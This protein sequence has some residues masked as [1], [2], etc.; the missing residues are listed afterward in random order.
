MVGKNE[1]DG[2]TPEIKWMSVVGKSLALICLKQAELDD[3]DIGTKGKFLEALG[4][5]RRDIAAILDTTEDT[6]R[7]MVRDARKGGSNR[8]KKAAKS[9][10]K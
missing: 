3:A 2:Q 5:G 10:K 9:K 6:V 7:V 1:T 8:G 4:L